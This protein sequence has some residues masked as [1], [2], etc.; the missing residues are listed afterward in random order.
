MQ[1]RARATRRALLEAAA[2]LFIEHGYART[3]INEISNLSGRTSGAVYFHYSSKEKLALAVVREQFAAWPMLAD[4]YAAPG[5]PPLE[6]LVALSFDVA[7]ALRDDVM[8]RAGA[9]L[10]AERR[11]IDVAIPTPFAIWTAAVTRLLAEARAD[12]ELDDGIEPSDTAATLV[13][14]FF[15]LYDLAEGTAEHEDLSDRLHR[16]WLL[17]LKALQ[18]RPEPAALLARA[19]AHHRPTPTG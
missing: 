17:I 10:W 13:S 4:R 2:H 1:D 19:L 8:T 14:A 12:G 9:R 11:T 3:S 6:K 7:E 5:I 16:W 15:G 18:A